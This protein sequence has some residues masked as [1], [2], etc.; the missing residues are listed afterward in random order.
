MKTSK[1][2]M[3]IISVTLGALAIVALRPFGTDIRQAAILAVVAAGIACWTFK[4]FHKTLISAA[5]VVALFLLQSAPTEKLLTFPLSSTFPMILLCYLFSRGISNSGITPMVV[6]PLLVRYAKTPVKIILISIVTL[7]LTIYAIPQPLVRLITIA[8]ILSA[9]L[10]RTNAS[11]KT[12]QLLMFALFEFY[13]IVNAAF[14]DADIIFNTSAVGFAGINMTSWEWMRYMTVPTT[15]YCAAS[16]MLF[17]FL[18]RKDLLGIQIKINSASEAPRTAFN[19]K[20]KRV[21]AIVVITILFWITKPVH[22]ISENIITLIAVIAMYLLRI[23]K[24]KDIDSIDITTLVFL[25]AAYSIGGAITC[26]GTAEKLMSAVSHLLPDKFGTGYI[27]ILVA[28]SMI[29]HFLLGSNTTALS[30]AIPGLMA[31]SQGVCDPAALTLIVYVSLVPHHLLPFHCIGLAIGE[32]NGYFKGDLIYKFGLPMMGM[33]LFALF[34]L[35]IPWWNFIG[36]L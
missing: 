5:I 11:G 24:P 36:L 28:I 33:I 20:Q 25:T 1:K 6:D 26:S 29:L 34:A 8:Q 22:H 14:L 16:V 4:L 21:V 3:Y 18:Y 9:F 17:V 19:K 7:L 35:Y 32:G 31:V 23:L 10:D 2:W 13:I 27:L 30:V 15:A 12:K